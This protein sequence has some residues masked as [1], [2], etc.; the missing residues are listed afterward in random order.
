MSDDGEEEWVDSDVDERL[1]V[2]TAIIVGSSDGV[3]G[4]SVE[5][6]A[7]TARRMYSTSVRA[8]W[9]DVFGSESRSGS[10]DAE[11]PEGRRDRRRHDRRFVSCSG[12]RRRALHDQ[13]DDHGEEGDGAQGGVP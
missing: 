12:A 4:D 8:R 2:A 1:P 7:V 9:D 3:P 11:Q 6:A 13:A 5:D 10:D